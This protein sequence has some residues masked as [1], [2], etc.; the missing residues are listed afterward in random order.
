MTDINKAIQI[1]F[2][3]KVEYLVEN[4]ECLLEAQRSSDYVTYVETLYTN[5][6]LREGNTEARITE[7]FPPQ[8]NN[9]YTSPMGYDVT[10]EYTPDQELTGDAGDWDVDVNLPPQEELFQEIPAYYPPKKPLGHGLA[11]NETPIDFEAVKRWE[12]ETLTKPQSTGPD[13]YGEEFELT[14]EEIRKWRKKTSK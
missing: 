10:F 8:S 11:M 3:D 14:P 2:E 13:L 12:E 6:I 7:E 1:P 5:S 9:I 4:G